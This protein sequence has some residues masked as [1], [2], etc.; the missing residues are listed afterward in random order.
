VFV[1]Y[2]IGRMLLFRCF[3]CD[4]YIILLFNP[5]LILFI[6]KSFIFVIKTGQ[7]C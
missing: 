3:N 4:K 5:E 2:S 7:P 6:D 1:L